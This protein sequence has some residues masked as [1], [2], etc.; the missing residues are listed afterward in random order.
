[1]KLG[2]NSFFIREGEYIFGSFS[3]GGYT[4]FQNVTFDEEEPF[5]DT[6]LFKYEVGESDCFYS[7]DFETGAIEDAAT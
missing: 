5:Y 3:W 4:R 6:H 2:W 1:M 7:A